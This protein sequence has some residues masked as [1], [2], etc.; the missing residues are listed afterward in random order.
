MQQITHI[1]NILCLSITNNYFCILLIVIA[2][3]YQ[4]PIIKNM[5]DEK[6]L[7]LGEREMCFVDYQYF[8]GNGDWIGNLLE[9][10]QLSKYHFF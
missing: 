8:L 2:V 1:Q 3:D 9:H 4:N 6:S 7:H 5:V 10:L